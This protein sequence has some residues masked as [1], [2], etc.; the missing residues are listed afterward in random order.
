MRRRHQKNP[1]LG[2]I[3]LFSI[4]FHI[5]ALPI[6]AHFGALKKI[7]S[8]FTDMRMVVLAPPPPQL[9]QEAEKAKVEPKKAPVAAQKGKASGAHQASHAG[10][11]HPHVAVAAGGS[12]DDGG[13]AIDEGTGKVGVVPTDTS[14]KTGG[15]PAKTDT[16]TDAGAGKTNVAA[17]VIQSTKQDVT[18]VKPILPQVPVITPQPAPL[19]EPVFTEAAPVD[20]HQPQPTIPDELRADNLDATAVVEVVVDAGGKATSAAIT[21]T[22]GKKDLDRLALET[23]KQWRFKPATRDGAPIESRVRLHIEFQVN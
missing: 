12:G 7:Q 21:S 5:L 17:P 19:H 22:T 1:L 15:G 9:K 16:Q 13:P 3:I 6:L 10:G 4:G 11:N 23:A 8:H 18:V 20:D 2:R 14:A